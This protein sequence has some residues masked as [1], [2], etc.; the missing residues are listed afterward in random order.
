MTID[1]INH[2][3]T[4]RLGLREVYDAILNGVPPGSAAL[5][6]LPAAITLLLQDGQTEK[7]TAEADTAPAVAAKPRKPRAPREAGGQC[8]EGRT[9]HKFDSVLNVCKFCNL[10]NPR[11]AVVPGVA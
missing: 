5:M 11:Q 10:R 3:V 1:K 7:D 6:A 2:R 4:V 9:R 8:V